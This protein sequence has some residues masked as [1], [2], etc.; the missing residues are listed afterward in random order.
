MIT[1]LSSV[2]EYCYELHFDSRGRF[3]DKSY[4]SGTQRPQFKKISKLTLMEALWPRIEWPTKVWFDLS[5]TSNRM[6]R[7]Q[8]D[9]H[10]LSSGGPS[11]PLFI[12][13]REDMRKRRDSPFYPLTQLYINIRA[14]WKIFYIVLLLPSFP[15]FPSARY[16]NIRCYIF[17]SS[18]RPIDHENHTENVKWIT[19]L[20]F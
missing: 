7:R 14:S 1:S 17:Q 5:R 13:G 15:E 19:K 16:V 3:R 10:T 9:V 4:H 11:Y 2:I 6:N 20:Q 12:R 8:R 18:K